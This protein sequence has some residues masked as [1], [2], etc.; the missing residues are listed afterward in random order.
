[1]V[2][3]PG[4]QCK[5]RGFKPWSGN[6]DATCCA[7]WPKNTSEGVCMDV[8]NSRPHFHSNLG[9]EGREDHRLKPEVR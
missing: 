6:Q 9:E 4:F 3:T 2:K 5:G 1:M 7:V 8:C